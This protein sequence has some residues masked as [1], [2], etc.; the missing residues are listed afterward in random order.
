[1]YDYGRPCADREQQLH[2]R[3]GVRVAI[4]KTGTV[5]SPLIPTAIVAAIG[6]DSWRSDAPAIFFG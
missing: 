4:S 1:V 3:T 5:N 2:A 6:W